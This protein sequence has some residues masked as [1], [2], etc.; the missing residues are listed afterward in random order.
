MQIL[1]TTLSDAGVQAGYSNA[2]D[3]LGFSRLFSS[4][5][6]GSPAEVT[7]SFE[8]SAN[9]G[10]RR[11][12]TDS[13]PHAAVGSEEDMFT[14]QAPYVQTAIKGSGAEEIRFTPEEVRTI[15]AGLQR[16]GLDPAVINAVME[17]AGNPMG[18]T[19]PDIMKAIVSTVRT[20]AKLTDS[21]LDR[22]AAFMKRLDP[23]GGL[24][25]SV[26]ADILAGRTMQAWERIVVALNALDPDTVLDI[27]RDDVAA[28]GKGLGL[29]ENTQ[30]ALLKSFGGASSLQLSAAGFQNLMTPAQHELGERQAQLEKLA[31]SFERVLSPVAQQA[32][33]RI[34][35]EEAAAGRAERN[36]EHSKTLIKDTVTEKGLGRVDEDGQPLGKDGS[37]AAPTRTE[38]GN[39]KAVQS[40]A[41]VAAGKAA[42]L[43]VAREGSGQRETGSGDGRN[44]RSGNNGREAGQ[45]ESL[46][47]G[48][49]ERTSAWDALLDKVQYQG[50]SA[51]QA[52]P[53]TSPTQAAPQTGQAIPQ[54][55]P[56]YAPQVLKQVEQGILTGSKNGLQRLELQLTPESLGAV[57]VVL[58]TKN[59]EISALLRPERPETAALMNQQTDQVRFALEQQGLKVDKVEVQTQLQDQRNFMTWQG[60][61]QHNASQEQQAQAKDQ[62]RILRLGRL[63]RGGSDDFGVERIMQSDGQ[64]LRHTAEVAGRGLHIIT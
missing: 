52:S 25:D 13:N 12:M 14:V 22:I 51:G 62:Q 28:L 48:K 60:M 32:R 54:Q 39:A 26:T 19:T 57:T 34:A 8:D 58:T 27:S 59:G 11:A 44:R 64:V 40:R 5:M 18:V 45:A 33:M 20:A 47:L 42:E 55:L 53:L 17:L 2:R 4:Y 6:D 35:A 9:S 50:S 1:P 37:K 43:A 63:H 21:D 61:D 56:N 30:S 10:A 3:D 23:E 49:K 29:S 31:G 24:A 7:P 15:A 16:E 36:V 38:E 46:E 41:E